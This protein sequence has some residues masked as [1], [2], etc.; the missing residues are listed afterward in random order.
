MRLLIKGFSITVSPLKA[1]IGS[2]KA[3]F[4]APSISQDATC[5]SC[6]KLWDLGLAQKLQEDSSGRNL[7]KMPKCPEL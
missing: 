1:Q 5:L 2:P 6:Q 4:V 7:Y 3:V